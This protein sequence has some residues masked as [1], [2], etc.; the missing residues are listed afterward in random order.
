MHESLGDTKPPTVT[1]RLSLLT[2]AL[3]PQSSWQAGGLPCGGLTAVGKGAVTLAR[4]RGG[5]GDLVAGHPPATSRRQFAMSILID[6]TTTV[7]VQGITGREGRIIT[8]D[9]L[10]YGTRVVAGV[11]PGRGG[12]EVLGVP[13][14]DSLKSAVSVHR[15]TA[16]VI[17]VPPLGVR[18]AALEAIENAIPLLLIVTERIPRKDVCEVLVAASANGVRVLGPNSLGAIAPGRCKLGTVGGSLENTLQTFMRGSVGILSRSGG[19]TSELANVLTTRGIGQSACVSVG[20]DPLIGST[21]KD[22]FLLFEQDSETMAVVL[23]CEPGG[24][25]EEEL[26]DYYKT[27]RSRKPIVA[28]VAGRFVDDMPGTRFGHAGV[29][30][31]GNRGSA[32]GKI[33]AF[34]AAGVR[35]A[36]RLRDLVPLVT[37]CVPGLAMPG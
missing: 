34:E 26:S 16:A 14:Y 18:D 2:G 21:F 29:I 36:H 4:A 15:P 12:Q 8:K 6:E 24:T 17:C 10:D 11:T 1:G 31:D 19:M 5:S 37:E 32:R 27:V 13:V 33:E 7:V 25:M 30:V 35:V 20:G 9:S 22:L 23:F 28:F 3:S